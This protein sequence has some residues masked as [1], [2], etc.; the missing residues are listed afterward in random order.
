MSTPSRKPSKSI[1]S[2]PLV[3]ASKVKNVIRDLDCRADG[4]LIDEINR[5]VHEMLRTAAAR[6]QARGQTT[7]RPHDL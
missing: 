5:K 7:I 6:A 3:V 2:E 1:C 4:E